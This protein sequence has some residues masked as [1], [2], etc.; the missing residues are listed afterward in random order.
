MGLKLNRS[1][2]RHLLNRSTHEL[3]PSITGKLRAAR[4]LALQRQKVAH[5]APALA[6][7]G[8]H[9]FLLHSP[10]RAQRAW[11]WGAAATLALALA[12]G[13]AYWQHQAVH[14]HAEL[15]IAILTDDLPVHMYVD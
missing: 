6:W 13:Y 3:P 12:V 15:D 8:E 4:Q 11:Q 2:L 9:G 14:E 1:E 10:G 7:L 5:T